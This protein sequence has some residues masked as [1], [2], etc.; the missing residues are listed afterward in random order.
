MFTGI[1]FDKDGTLFDFRSSW[2]VWCRDVLADMARTPQQAALMA[3]AIGFDPQAFE[4]APDSPVIAGTVMELAQALSPYVPEVSLHDLVDRLNAIAASN[5]MVPAVP[6]PAFFSALKARGMQVGLAT[7]DSEI[8]ARAHLAAHDLTA[9]FDFI[10]GYDSGYGGKPAPGQL[11]AFAQQR[12]LDPAHCAMVG[13]SAHDLVAGRAA[14]MTCIAVL[15]GIAGRD[16]LTPLADV[17]FTDI[18][19]ILPWLAENTP[20]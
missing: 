6:L 14:G 1:I 16:A 18:A 11:L 15:T 5:P 7:N 8:P 2:G 3:K 20:A 10:A 17:V 4:F 13:D 9:Y 19:E 12:G